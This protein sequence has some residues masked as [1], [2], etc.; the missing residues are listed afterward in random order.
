MIKVFVSQNPSQEPVASVFTFTSSR[1][2]EDCDS[3][4]EA[5]Q[6]AIAERNRPKTVADV[7]KEGEEGLLK[8][9]DLQVSL[10]RQDVELGKMFKAMVMDDKM[11]SA[12]QFWRA[13]VVMTHWGFTDNSIFYELMQLK[14]RSREDRIMFFQYSSRKHRMVRPKSVFQQ[15]EY[16]IYSNSI[17]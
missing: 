4:K 9:T 14:R 13:R 2:R 5:I 12:E 16:G 10:L 3:V 11:L 1:P 7:L 15:S 6:T 8:N 17:H